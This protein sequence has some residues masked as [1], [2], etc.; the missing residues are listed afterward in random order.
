MLRVD[1]KLLLLIEWAGN[2]ILIILVQVVV[3]LFTKLAEI[4][5]IFRISL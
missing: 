2:I 5:N 1:L 4:L 3:W